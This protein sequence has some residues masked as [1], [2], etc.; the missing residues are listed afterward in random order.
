MNIVR[1]KVVLSPYR[2]RVTTGIFS[3]AKP[4]K[5]LTSRQISRKWGHQRARYCAWLKRRGS[6]PQGRK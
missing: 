5:Q 4:R 6:M 2:V 3:R 1:K